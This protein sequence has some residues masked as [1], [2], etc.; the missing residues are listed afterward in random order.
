MQYFMNLNLSI[1]NLQ[2]ALPHLKLL[3]LLS[4]ISKLRKVKFYYHENSKTV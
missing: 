2:L 3:L 4:L 1:E